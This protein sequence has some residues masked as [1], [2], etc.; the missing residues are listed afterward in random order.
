ML[1]VSCLEVDHALQINCILI[2]FVATDSKNNHVKKEHLVLRGLKLLHQGLSFRCFPRRVYFSGSVAEDGSRMH[3]LPPASPHR[4]HLPK[5]QGST[6]GQEKY[7]QANSM[8]R[9][10]ELLKGSP[11][12]RRGVAYVSNFPHQ[13]IK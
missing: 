1:P 8:P 5:A 3:R 4:G 12:T 13:Q 7:C 2:I 11:G 10:P 6:W 9:A